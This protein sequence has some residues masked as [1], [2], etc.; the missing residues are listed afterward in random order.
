LESDV[1]SEAREA[2]AKTFVPGEGRTTKET[3]KTNFTPEQKAQIRD[4]IANA[5]SP[6]DIERI[7]SAVKRGEFPTVVSASENSNIVQN[8]NET[9][10]YSNMKRTATQLTNEEAEESA[11]ASTSKRTRV[12][13]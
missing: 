6:A 7:E 10:E 3:F 9:D 13:T 1:Q 5:Q 12:S 11:E 4:M 2:S 8:G